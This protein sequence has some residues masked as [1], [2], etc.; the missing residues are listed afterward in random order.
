MKIK[1]GFDP[2]KL[3][4]SDEAYAAFHLGGGQMTL[5]L[6]ALYKKHFIT[7][8]RWAIGLKYLATSWQLEST[9]SPPYKDFDSFIRFAHE[10][11]IA[12]IYPRYSL[13]FNKAFIQWA[14]KYWDYLNP[15]IRRKVELEYNHD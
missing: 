15:N 13:S 9:R 10:I 2:D 1:C 3:T 5:N 4:Q 6:W 14:V 7:S 8:D 12:E 11:G